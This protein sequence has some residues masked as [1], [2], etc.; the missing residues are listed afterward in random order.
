MHPAVS[1]TISSADFSCVQ[2]FIEELTWYGLQRLSIVVHNWQR[3]G[4]DVKLPQHF[5]PNPSRG[6]EADA[7]SM[8]SSAT[9]LGHLIALHENYVDM[10]PDSPA[11]NASQLAYSAGNSTR[12]AWLNKSTGVQSYLSMNTVLPS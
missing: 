12:R 6:G 8:I 7:K 3:F 1:G 11:W 9:S 4:Y 5:P 2:S 10:Y